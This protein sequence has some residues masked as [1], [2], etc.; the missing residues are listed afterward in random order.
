MSTERDLQIDDSNRTDDTPIATTT[1]TL[2]VCAGG[3]CSWSDTLECVTRPER[4]AHVLCPNCRKQYL[5]VS[6]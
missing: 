1:S 6:S 5:G 2:D 4:G 3:G